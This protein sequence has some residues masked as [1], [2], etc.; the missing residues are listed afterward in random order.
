MECTK[1]FTESR[2]SSYQWVDGRSATGIELKI[3][4]DDE[5][6]RI[7]RRKRVLRGSGGFE[8]SGP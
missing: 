5:N 2:I 4:D 1:D 8:R 6:Y 7:G 3:G